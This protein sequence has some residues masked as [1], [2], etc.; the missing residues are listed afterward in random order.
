LKEEGES[1]V[2]VDRTRGWIGRD[3]SRRVGEGGY[4]NVHIVRR[5]RLTTARPAYMY[6]ARLLPESG[7][8]VM[9]VID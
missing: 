7:Q 3:H 4:E 6:L 1:G 2:G 5:R 9:L 8:M